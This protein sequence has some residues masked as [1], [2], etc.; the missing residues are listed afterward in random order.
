MIIFERFIG[1]MRFVPHKALSRHGAYGVMAPSG[2]F[3]GKQ[4]AKRL[5][6]VHSDEELLYYVQRGYSVQMIAEETV[7]VCLTQAE[8]IVIRF[9]PPYV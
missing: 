9:V 4:D 2:P 7:Q 3:D 5:I 1:G 8:D 6:A